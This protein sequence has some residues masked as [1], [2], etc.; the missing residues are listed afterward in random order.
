MD[1]PNTKELMEWLDAIKSGHTLTDY[2][3]FYI[4]HIRENLAGRLSAGRPK[5]HANDKERWRFHNAR[6]RAIKKRQE[7]LDTA[8]DKAV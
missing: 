1:S 5:I 8:T 7:S 2:D 6:R 4:R 3:M